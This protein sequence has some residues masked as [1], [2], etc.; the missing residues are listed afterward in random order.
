[1]QFFDARRF[2][3]A[4]AVAGQPGCGARRSSAVATWLRGRRFAPVGLALLVGM[5]AAGS[6]AAAQ[7]VGVFQPHCAAIVKSGSDVAITAQCDIGPMFS[8]KIN[9]VAYQKDKSKEPPGEAVFQP[10]HAAGKIAAV[11][12]AVD[13]SDRKRARTVT[14]GVTDAQRL[15]ETARTAGPNDRFGLAAIEGDRL[16]VVAPIGSGRDDITRA[17]QNI[18]ADG[19]A[20][21]GTRALLDAISLVAQ[22]PADRHILVIAS[23]G[24][25]EDKNYLGDQVLQAARSG[26]VTIVTL[27]YRERTGD[28]PELNSLKQLAAD[29][30]GY[31][32]EPGLP[33]SRLDDGVITRFGQYVGSGGSATFLLDKT[34]PRGRYIINLELEGGAVLAGTYVAE[35][36]PPGAGIAKVQTASPAPP[37]PAAK[38]TTTP[39]LATGPQVG[40]SSPPLPVPPPVTAPAKEST[41]PATAP[42]PAPPLPRPSAADLYADYLAQ[43]LEIWAAR[44][45][46]VV[47]IGAG[48]ALV[49]ASLIGLLVHRVRRVR[50]YAWLEVTNPRPTRVPVTSPGVRLG[51]HTDNDIRFDDKSVHRYHAVLARE[52]ATGTFVISDVSRDQARSNGILV[53]GELIHSKATLANGDLV[54]LG[55]VAFR[56]RYA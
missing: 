56:F 9:R 22:A 18:R 7:D 43:F 38:P 5:A 21:D 33:S 15:I 3:S 4:E 6:P 16:D 45:M 40:P 52:A 51:R 47:G 28:G 1:M 34:D 27:G 8:A 2:V 23:D 12:V 20:A 24:K 14:L 36:A 42:P 39:Q 48:A 44:P 55:E 11:L 50:V 46:T 30:G 32:A 31:Y 53:N 17:A 26:N 37:I 41:L 10:F 54:E 25:V 35:V 29:T 49:L 19:I 13:R